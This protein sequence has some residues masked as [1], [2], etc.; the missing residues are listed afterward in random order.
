MASRYPVLFTM[1]ETRKGG[2]I[3]SSGYI[4]YLEKHEHQKI[5]LLR[6]TRTRG[7]RKE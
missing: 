3:K 4:A 2:C 5:S 6:V 7:I 1:G